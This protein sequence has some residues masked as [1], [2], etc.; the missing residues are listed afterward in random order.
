[1]EISAECVNDVVVLLGQMKQMNM[2]DLLDQRI[3][4]HQREE[5]LSWGWVLCIWLAYAVSQGD[6]R[7]LSV[8]DWIRQ[9][10]ET[11]ELVTGLEIRE[12]DFTDDRLTIAL[13]HLSEDEW[14]NQIEQD[15]ARSL[16]RIY[17]LPQ[18]TLRADATTVSGYREGAEDSLWQFGHSKDDPTLRQVKVM[19]S[20]LDPLGLPIAM[21][22]LAGQNADDGLYIPVL[23]RTLAYLPGK[24][25]LVVGDCKLSALA[26]RAYLQAQGQ[27]YLTPLSQVG[28]VAKQMASWIEAGVALG[29]SANTVVVEDEEG[30]HEIARGYEFTRWC[31]SGEQSW[32][33]RVLVV[34]SLAW[35]LAEPT[36]FGKTA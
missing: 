33:E 8:R 12:L 9:T 30:T 6:H 2:P 36:P 16:V 3:S 15:L 22:V 34:Q 20:V 24:G 29:K 27:L 4:R 35:A 28:E 7:K 10:H 11:L 25:K 26:T 32:E 18:E 23:S 31:T 13:R 19:M 17:N 21:D 14:W 1:M 5:G